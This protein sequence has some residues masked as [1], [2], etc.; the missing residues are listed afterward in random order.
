MSDIEP[1]RPTRK[2]NLPGKL[3]HL[4]ALHVLPGLWLSVLLLVSCGQGNDTQVRRG[5]DDRKLATVYDKSLYLS[6]MDGMIHEGM[7]PD[8]SATLVKAYIRD[9]VKQAA[10]L[11]EA[12]TKLPAELN[13]DKLVEDYRASLVIL[14]YE[15]A[16]LDKMLDS[17]V[18]EKELQGF[19][20]SNKDEFQLE[21][22][23]VRCHF[24][25]ASR[26]ANNL[27]K[28]IEWWDSDVP[29]IRD[30]LVQWADIHAESIKLDTSVW[31]T[32]GELAA[33]MPQGVITEENIKR[34]MN[35]TRRYE[36]D[37]YFLKVFEI[38]PRKQF[39]P[40]TQIEEQIRKV[41]IHKRRANLLNELKEKLYNEALNNKQ[42]TIYE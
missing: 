23:S 22:L 40:L 33:M 24:M 11:K 30:S 29:E 20:D 2:N 3:H 12:E 28:A 5:K 32:I 15:T 26:K 9:W 18:S 36:E 10:L 27:K 13:I 8:D 6:D 14:N 39:A 31:Y 34:R 19:Y 21:E 42:V 38:L 41:I 17:T 7:S 4:S 25:K 16:V 37:Y 35:F 1:I